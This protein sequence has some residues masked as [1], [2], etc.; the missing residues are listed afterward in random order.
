MLRS[1]SE[2]YARRARE[3][4]D[5]VA[6][7]G[8]HEEVGPE[9]VGLLKRITQLR[10]LCGEAEAKLARYVQQENHAAKEGGEEGVA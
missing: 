8:R 6:R 5:T 3:L 9:L 2:Q 1:L 4:S 10:E 7:L